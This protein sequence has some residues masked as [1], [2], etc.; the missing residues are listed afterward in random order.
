MMYD[1]TGGGKLLRKYN[2]CTMAWWHTYKHALMRLWQVFARDVFAPLFHH[3]YPGHQFFVKPSSLP[4]IMVHMIYLVMSYPSV[5]KNI[6][7]LL[8]DS[9]LG[10]SEAAMVADLQYLLS[11]AIPVVP[12]FALLHSSDIT[13]SI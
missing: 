12:I 3:L 1:N 9:S 6:Q 4:S 13:Y 7:V 2:S 8:N 10:P 5:K 11:V